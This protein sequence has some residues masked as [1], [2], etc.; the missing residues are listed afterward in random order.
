[1]TDVFSVA[2]FVRAPIVIPLVDAERFNWEFSSDISGYNSRSLVD[3]ERFLLHKGRLSPRHP[4]RLSHW[5]HHTL[6]GRAAQPQPC[7]PLSHGT[8]FQTVHSFE[9][10]QSDAACR[11]MP[12]LVS[13]CVCSDPLH[14][15]GF[16]RQHSQVFFRRVSSPK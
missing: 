15:I 2:D 16:D 12:R 7:S 11:P 8:L 6:C 1:M 5:L 10:A 9:E 4:D 3:Y 14:S 13:Y